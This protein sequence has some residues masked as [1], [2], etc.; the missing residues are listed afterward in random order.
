[1]AS[2][3]VLAGMAVASSA[4]TF[5]AGKLLGQKKKARTGM[6]LASCLEIYEI[7]RVVQ[8]LPGGLLQ[9]PRSRRPST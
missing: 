5:L 9:G 3:L 1:M 7:M 2:A 6:G 4:G 8:C